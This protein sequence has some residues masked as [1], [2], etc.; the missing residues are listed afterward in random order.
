MTRVIEYNTLM[1][2]VWVECWK[3]DQCGHRWIKTENWPTQCASSK[4]RKRS[5]NESGD[6]ARQTHQTSGADQRLPEPS[7]VQVSNPAPPTK[8]SMQALRDICAGNV[9]ANAAYVA[10]VDPDNNTVFLEA[11]DHCRHTEWAED[12]EQ[13]RCRLPLG[14]KGKCVPGE[15]V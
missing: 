15:R 6:G 2:T 3:C 7:V 5:W 14:H 13:Y 12:G 8:P 1:A 11:S 4:C 9:S 10:N